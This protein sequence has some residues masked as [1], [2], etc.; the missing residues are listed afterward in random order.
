[1]TLPRRVHQVW[2]DF[3]RSMDDDHHRIMKWNISKMLAASI[4]HTVWD[5]PNAF[6]FVET[7]YPFYT[8]FMRKK[9]KYEI[10]KCDFFRYLIMYHFGGV[11][12]DLD[13][14]IVNDVRN[15][16]DHFDN[17]D[18]VLFEE[19]FNS[20]NFNNWTSSEGS[21]HNGFLLS[22][23]RNDFWLKMINSLVLN[24]RHVES[25][26][27]VWKLSGTNLLRNTYIQKMVESVASSDV[28]VCTGTTHVPYYKVCPFKCVED[29]QRRE[30]NQENIRL[31]TKHCVGP[32]DVP[33]FSPN[34]EGN[35][36][37]CFYNFDDVTKKEKDLF[38]ESYAV[39]VTVPTGSLWNS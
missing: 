30:S 12:M 20:A 26:A 9:M 19:W 5:L 11:Y 8:S 10:V 1:M 35:K 37:W 34:A 38:K 14:V 27:D 16:F 13:F 24:E 29:I 31:V 4:D 6:E 22:K 23:P 25:P 36:R 18:V 33:P 17:K 3:G 15:L 7:H 32:D 2:F 28:V 39:C 21:L